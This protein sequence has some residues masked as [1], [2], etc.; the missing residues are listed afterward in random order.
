MRPMNKLKNMYKDVVSLEICRYIFLS[1]C[2][3]RR[4]GRS[5][6]LYVEKLL[7]LIVPAKKASEVVNILYPEPGLGCFDA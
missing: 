3:D 4:C 1:N 2:L 6:S 5:P 7:V